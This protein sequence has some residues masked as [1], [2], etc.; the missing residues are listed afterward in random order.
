MSDKIGIEKLRQIGVDAISQRTHIPKRNVERL[1]AEDFS[2]FSPVQLSGFIRILEREYGVDLSSWKPASTAQRYETTAD[3]PASKTPHENDP[4]TDAAKTRRRQQYVV[5]TFAVLLAV[6]IAVTVA[7]LGS[8]RG[9]TKIELNNTAIDKARD[10]LANLASSSRRSTLEAVETI[11]RQHQE[12][13]SSSSEAVEYEDV[14]IR[15]RTKVWLGVID[16]KTHKRYTRTT[17]HPWELDGN[18]SWLIVT[19]HGLLSI[20]CGGINASFAQRDRLLF[21]YEDGKCREIDAQE[22]RARNGG[23]IW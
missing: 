10:N 14:V 13:A 12:E 19:G 1:L 8:G 6:A 22:F 15:P 4:F 5:W 21:L 17:A 3:K 23:R 18:R 9:K 11:Q 16:A 7:V 2:A 20:E